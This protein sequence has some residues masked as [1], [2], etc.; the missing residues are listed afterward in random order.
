MPPVDAA[1]LARTW[2]H[3]HEE[4][5]AQC[6]VYRPAG[7]AFPPARGRSGFTL[8]ADGSAAEF[9]PGAADQ[10]IS[11]SARWA[12]GAGDRLQIFSGGATSPSRV[13]GIESH[14]RDKLVLSKQP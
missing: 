2:V 3:S 1:A 8:N 11:G 12:L 7:F 5:T 9:G 14:T 4:D 13:L 6:V 10:P